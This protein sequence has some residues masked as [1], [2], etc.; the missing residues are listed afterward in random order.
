MIFRENPFFMY[1]FL[2]ST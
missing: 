1:S 2:C